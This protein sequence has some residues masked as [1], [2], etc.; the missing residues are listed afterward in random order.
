MQEKKFHIPFWVVKIGIT[1]VAVCILCAGAF[2]GYKKFTM[3]QIEKRYMNVSSQ[4]LHV[5]ELTTLK[6]D[7]SDV[8]CVKKQA[9]GGLAKA[10]SIVKYRGVIR[11]G[12][13][14]VNKIKIH[15][16]SD[17]KSVAVSVPKS[18]V[19]GNGLIS[20]EVFD[21]KKSIFVPITTEEIFKEIT[22]GMKKTEAACVTDGCLAEADVQVKKVITGLLSAA[23]FTNISVSQ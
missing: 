18:E 8:V 4:I 5:A 11:A 2:Y 15:V 9:A 19:L 20:E 17:G 6:N 22:V 1:L 21:E 3:V 16:S 13:R 7:Y 23:G 10:Y 12:I 14:D